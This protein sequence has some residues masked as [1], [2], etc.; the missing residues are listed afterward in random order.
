MTR[1]EPTS[2]SLAAGTD[3]RTAACAAQGRSAAATPRSTSLST[4][5]SPATYARGQLRDEVDRVADDGDRPR[6]AIGHTTAASRVLDLVPAAVRGRISARNG[7]LQQQ[8]AVA[9]LR[10]AGEPVGRGD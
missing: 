4:R 3:R 1:R 6:G 10:T 7:R 5:L 9:E 8:V 2:T